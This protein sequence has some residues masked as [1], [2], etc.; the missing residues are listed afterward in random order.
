MTVTVSLQR[1]DRE[2][3]ELYQRHVDTACR[4]CFSYMKNRADTEDMVQDTFIKLISSGACF[5]SVEHEKAWLIVTASN[6]CKNT[7]RH[8]WRRR[9]N[10]EDYSSLCKEED[11]HLDDVLEAM[12][13]SVSCTRAARIWRPSRSCLIFP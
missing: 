1:T 10:M 6:L 5:N 12:W 13:F 4:V 3:A 8:W 7:L 11:L 2:I 9:E